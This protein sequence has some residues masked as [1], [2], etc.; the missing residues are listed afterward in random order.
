M[1]ILQAPHPL[2]RTATY[3]PNPV[4]SDSEA[5]TDELT[6]QRAMDGTLYTY[7]KTKNEKRKLLM[8]FDLTREKGLELRAFI[9][10]YYKSSIFLTDHLDVT[11]IVYF[12]SNPF[13]FD[14]KINEARVIT[15]EFEGIKQ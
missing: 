10:A 1:V 9:Q 7:I 6:Q 14:V 11:W 15:L 13:E 12:T 4:F 3:L 2:L 8:S 5:L